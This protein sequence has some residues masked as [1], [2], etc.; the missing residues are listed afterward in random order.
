MT[1]DSKPTV[2]VIGAG[3]AGLTAA[4]KLQHACNVTLFEKNDYIGGHTRTL[5][6][7]DGP[8]EGTPVDTGFIV[9]NH[10]NYPHF[11]AL[12]RE[13]EVELEDSDMS[14]S[15]HD[16]TSGYAYAGTTLRGIFPSWKHLVSPPHWTLLRELRRFGT[17]GTRALADGSAKTQS[18]GDFLQT[19][20]FSPV[21]RDRYLFAMGA[22]IWSSP[23]ESLADFPAEPYLHFFQNHGLLTLKNRPQWRIVRGG[24]QTYVRKALKH[25]KADV[26]VGETPEKI[27]R[28]S[29]KVDLLFSDGRKTS[30]DH[31]VIGAH[32]DEALQL[33]GDPDAD[34]SR[35]LGAWTY[36]PNDVVLHTWK[37]VMPVPRPCWASWNFAREIGFD[38]KKPVSVTYWMN[39]LQNLKTEREY[40]VTLNRLGD[41]PEEHVINRAVLHHPQYTRAAMDAQTPLRERNGARNTWLVGSYFGF[42]FHEDAVKSAV[43]MSEKLLARL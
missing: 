13:W 32:A 5:T 43:D 4:W 8:D 14:F 23:P 28:T 6:V 19:H 12:L 35:L 1:A 21:F 15:Y 18:L 20:K 37:D 22:A 27:F 36:Q 16:V 33:L 39:R 26:R 24:S 25:L 30:F 34:E 7:P 3:V 29:E 41:I 31:V 2:A 9:M 11:S 10:R 40:F 42:G 17:V 38:A